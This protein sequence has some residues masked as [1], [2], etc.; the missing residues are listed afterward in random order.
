MNRDLITALAALVAVLLLGTGG[1]A[2]Y[3]HFAQRG[4]RN[5]N[6]GN[7]RPSRDQWQGASGVDNGL[8]GP[9]LIFKAPEWGIRALYKNLL[10]YR[11]KYAADTV[12]EII[13][14]WAPA[15]D[16]NN[17]AAYIAAVDAAL[18]GGADT[19]L[20]LSDYPA[21]LE[22]I[23]KHEN[24]IQPYPPELIRKGIALA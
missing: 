22:A 20:P 21:L 16:K 23:I 13:S 14:R 10:T 7:L 12:R 4:I 3:T 19:V 2:V 17:T 11:T 9:Y 1:Y 8:N 5:N 18:P 24:G 6:P 15:N